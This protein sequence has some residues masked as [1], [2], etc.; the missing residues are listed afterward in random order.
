[1]DWA[2]RRQNKRKV[3]FEGIDIIKV[4]AGGKIQTLHAYW[5]PDILMAQ[6]Q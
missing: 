3:S 2:R 4:N 6:L 5:N 1:M